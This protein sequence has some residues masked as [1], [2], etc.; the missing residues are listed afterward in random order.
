VSRSGSARELQQRNARVDRHRAL[1]RPIALHYGA[2]CRESVEDLTQVGLLG[3]LRAA[4][5]FRP[6]D[7]T[8]FPAF[9]R[10]HVRGAILHYLR[11]QAPAIRLP[12]RQQELEDRVRRL[13][14]IERDPDGRP[15]GE[16]TL[17]IRLG[18]TAAQWQRFQQLRLLAKPVALDPAHH[19]QAAEA[20]MDVARGEERGQVLLLLADLEDRQRGVV[21]EVVLD[22]RSLRET[23]RRMGVSPMT[24]HRALA[25]ALTELRRRLD[26]TAA[27][28][29]VSPL[30]RVPSEPRAC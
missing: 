26:G 18:L 30:H 25:R 17:R 22:G 1:V 27:L 23:A 5:L 8:P 28:S 15:L 4:E 11:D 21:Q 2:L 24:V 9:A 3:L 29:P 13:E 14:R 10:H 7:Q 20:E 6:A 19:D 12:R 16:D